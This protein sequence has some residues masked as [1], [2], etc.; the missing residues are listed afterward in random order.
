MKQLLRPLQW[1]TGAQSQE[2]P[3]V[4]YSF[5]ALLFLLTSYYL[6]KP[7]RSS[8]FLKE[9]DPTWLP[10]FF[11][12]LPILS[13]IITRLF[14]FFYNRVGRFRLI[15]LTYA[16]MI[17]CKIFFLL[18]LPRGGK[19]VTLAFYFWASVYFLLS[20]SILWGCISSIFNSEAGERSF[21]FIAFGGMSG[22][23]I[24]S[25]L[26]EGLA[27]S[28]L[29]DQ[30][31][32]ISAICMGLVLLFL[33]LAVAQ[34]PDFQEQERKE[35]KEPAPRFWQDFKAIWQH[36]YV[37]G[38]ATMVFALAFMNTVVEFKSQK[39]IDK[40]LASQQYLQ[41][42]KQLNQSLCSQPQSGCEVLHTEA[43][44]T[45]YSLKQLQAEKRQETLTQWLEKQHLSL[46]PQEQFQ[47][48][49]HYHETLESQTR[50]LFSRINFWINL[51]GV[52][53]LLLAARPLFKYAGVHRIILLL[54]FFFLL[55]GTLLLFPLELGLMTSILIGTG[56]LNYSL[57]KTAKELLYT[58]GNYEL[59][60]KFKPLIEGPVMRFGDVSAALFKILCLQVLHLPE[61]RAEW[62]LL[63]LGM[64]ITA[65][66]L[67]SM[68][69]TGQ[70]YQRLKK[71]TLSPSS[72]EPI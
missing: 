61:Q 24:G 43:F 42:F 5:F 64:L 4:L 16:V 30:A 23:L 51:I 18:T 20:I 70:T 9:F 25:R 12:A 38:I 15:W 55:L 3:R 52:G 22:A 71:Q 69:S 28:S 46:D 10:Y 54:P 2:L 53:L 66:W 6:V 32:L 13:L 65:F 37:R 67:V 39:V 72:A 8:Y 49:Q 41:D 35:S 14:N 17:G 59:R 47:I 36:K 11:L 40:K 58:Q 62:V 31:L 50:A 29:K 57:N 56:T 26:S 34:S 68:W 60:F 44:S 63:G 1:L 27:H 21:A 19:I 33:A 45:I 48:Y 7:L